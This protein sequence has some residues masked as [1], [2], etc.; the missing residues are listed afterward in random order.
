MPVDVCRDLSIIFLDYLSRRY[1]VASIFCPFDV[2]SVVV[3]SLS[4]CQQ[5][6]TFHA[7]LLL[8]TKLCYL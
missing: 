4:H 1:F 8:T 6:C 2:L 3:L 7:C 5:L